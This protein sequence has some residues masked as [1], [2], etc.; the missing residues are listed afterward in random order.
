MCGTYPLARPEV[1][2]LDKKN[3]GIIN[4]YFQIALHRDCPNVHSSL[5]TYRGLFSQSLTINEVLSN[6]GIFDCIRD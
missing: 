5:A 3:I 2:L 4:I 6:F 1:D